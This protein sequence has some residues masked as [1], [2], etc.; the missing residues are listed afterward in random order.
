MYDRISEAG[1]SGTSVYR[2]LLN[3]IDDDI[4]TVAAIG[5][6][7][8]ETMQHLQLFLRHHETT[9]SVL[10]RHHDQEAH[11][12]Q[13]GCH[14][15]DVVEVY[16]LAEARGIGV[17]RHIYNCPLVVSLPAGVKIGFFSD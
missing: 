8:L 14:C 2:C 10:Q 5:E 15:A 1:S 17:T 7:D 16:Q 12:F 9:I 13:I 6:H 3:S 4:H 11:L